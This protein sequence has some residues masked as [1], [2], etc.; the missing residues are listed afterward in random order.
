MFQNLTLLNMEE[1]KIIELKKKAGSLVLSLNSDLLELQ[2]AYRKLSGDTSQQ[3]S[4]TETDREKR[5]EEQKSKLEKIIAS[6]DSKAEFVKEA[7]LER[8]LAMMR[9]TIENTERVLRNKTEAGTEGFE[10]VDNVCKEAKDYVNK[11]AAADKLKAEN[12]E[13]LS[14]LLTEAISDDKNTQVE[15]SSADVISEEDIQHELS[16]LEKHVQSRFKRIKS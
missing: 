16:C 7:N 6:L 3:L 4:K 5:I 15:E 14:L 1:K 11:L 2:K 12:V 8:I 10:Q 9:I 13:N